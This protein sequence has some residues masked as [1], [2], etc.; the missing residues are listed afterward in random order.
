[1]TDQSDAE[2]AVRRYLLWLD[3]PSS[4]VDQAELGRRAEAV[5]AA[6]DPIEK[7]K[8]ITDLRELESIDADALRR[9][10]VEQ[11]AAWAEANRIAP[12]A[13][14][15]LGVPDTVLLEAGLL[16]PRGTTPPRRS[17]PAA[18]RRRGS[19][20]RRTGAEVRSHLMTVTGSFT[21]RDVIDGF[22]GSPQTVTTVVRELV[23]SGE[24]EALGPDPDHAGRGRAPLRY[25]R[26]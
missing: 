15:Q 21:L 16:R 6:T 8:R 24:V 10:F 20:A 22:G 11:A 1:M 13:F 23:D 7:L 25:R 14:T 9:R 17:S 18:P 5:K 3:D 26:R 2:D 4:L 19:A 12:E